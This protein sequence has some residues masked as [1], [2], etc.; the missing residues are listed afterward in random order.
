[1]TSERE[2]LPAKRENVP[3]RKQ[4]VSVG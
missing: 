1:V 4:R 2:I 3:S